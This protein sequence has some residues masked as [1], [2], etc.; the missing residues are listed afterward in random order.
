MLK[1]RLDRAEKVIEDKAASFQALQIELSRKE[2]A[3]QAM[4]E[5]EK[6]SRNEALSQVQEANTKNKSLLTELAQK[7]SHTQE[8][9]ER[10]AAAQ[11]PSTERG[12]EVVAL[13][14]RIAELEA[15]EKRLADR[16]MTISRRYEN[17]D[18]VN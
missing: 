9:A 17:N 14:L 1:A 12:R 3:F 11:A 4:L 6:L 7:D 18:L 10:L 15:T 13:K 8:L 16:A 2:G 5:T